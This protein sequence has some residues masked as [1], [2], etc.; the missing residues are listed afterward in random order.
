M[1]QITSVGVRALVDDN[2]E[3][4]KTSPLPYT[5][6]PSEGATMCADAGGATPCQISSNSIWLV[7][8]R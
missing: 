1:E 6:T 7:A 4:V 3:A 2:V 8:Y 5:L